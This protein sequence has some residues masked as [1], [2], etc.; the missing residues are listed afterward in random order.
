[1]TWLYKG[2]EFSDPE[3][4]YGF[5]YIITHKESGKKYIGR[6][7]FTLAGYKQVNGKRKKIR[8]DSGWQDY[9]GSSKTLLAEVEAQGKDKFTREIVRLCKSKSDCSYHESKLILET[10][11]LLKDDYYNDWISCKITRMHLKAIE[12]SS[13]K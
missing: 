9:W 4:F 6:K 2:S 8:K 3:S 11:A 5:V 10:D 7:Y 12:L 1:M 13:D